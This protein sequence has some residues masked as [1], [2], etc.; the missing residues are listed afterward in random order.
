MVAAP[1]CSGVRNRLGV[2]YDRALAAPGALQD[3]RASDEVRAVVQQAAHEV[4]RR[5]E[6]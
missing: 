1:C 5:A 3:D 6:H 2:P 4:L